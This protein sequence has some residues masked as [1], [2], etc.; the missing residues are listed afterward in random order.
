MLQPLSYAS[1]SRSTLRHSPS[2][3]L[4]VVV[5]FFQGFSGNPHDLE[6]F[7]VG[8]GILQRLTL[9][10]NGGEGAIDLLEL[11][12]IPLLTLQGLQSRW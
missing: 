12:L 7:C 10:L 3:D 8:G 5:G 4:Q 11:L 6:D 1:P 9:E 2:V